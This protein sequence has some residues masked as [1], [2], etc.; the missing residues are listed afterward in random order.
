VASGGT[1]S[2]GGT[3]GD[4][5]DSG[6]SGGSPDTTCGLSARSC[7]E[8]PRTCGAD[9]KQDCCSSGLVSGGSFNRSHE[10]NRPATLSAFRLDTY[11][12][13]V[14]RFRKFVE[15][16]PASRPVNGCGNNPHNAVDA[17]WDSAWD[18]AL[19]A[20]PDALRA[21]LSCAEEAPWS[22]SAGNAETLPMGC[23]SW[24]EA[25]AFCIWD[26]GRLPTE[27]EWNFAAA[28]GS[29]QRP[30]PWSTSP[31]DEAIDGSFATYCSASPCVSRS[32]G[33]RS[34]K[35]DGRWGH[36]DLAGSVREWVQDYYLTYSSECVDC[37]ALTDGGMRARRGGSYSESPP[38]LLTKYRDAAGPAIRMPN[39]G[40]RCAR[41]P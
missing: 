2:V 36:A 5:T 38:F 28:G 41:S 33:S 6:G 32:V 13:T 20:T 30:Y 31:S 7:S 19:P 26:G 12:V 1:S 21:A 8:L 18:S 11:E 15:A 34:P 37:A 40:V 3:A 17:G 23:L 16:Y 24:H 35:G 27:A 29:E 4:G 9:G 39:V 22:D 14:G 25:Y 10:A